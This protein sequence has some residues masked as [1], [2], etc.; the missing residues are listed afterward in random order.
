[1][2]RAKGLELH[3]G[4]LRR[5][6]E[7]WG[8]FSIAKRQA[9]G[10]ALLRLVDE[11]SHDASESKVEPFVVAIDRNHSQSPLETAY[12]EMLFM[13]DLYLRTGRRQGEPHNGI[14]VADRSH[15]ERAL[16]AWVEVARASTADPGRML[17]V[18]TLWQK[19]RSS[20]THEA[21]A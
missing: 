4:P 1:V 5:G 18:F 10:H 3:G 11:W 14:L 9:L 19:R 20:W 7:G 16:A 6:R 15:Y 2:E 13:F 21:H 17:G 8:G 12:G